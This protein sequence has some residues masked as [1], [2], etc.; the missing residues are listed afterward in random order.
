MAPL[1]RFRADDNHV[2]SDMAVEYYSQRASVPG[3]LII[4]E[5]TFLSPTAV[6]FLN[7]PMIHSQEQIAAWKRVIDAVHSKG[8]YIFCQLVASGREISPQVLEVT[9]QPLRGSSAIPMEPGAQVPYEMTENEVWGVVNDF[10]QAARNAIEAGF[11]GVEIHGANGYLTDQF[12]QD[13]ANQRTDQWGGSIENRSRFL[14]EISK[15]VVAAVGADRVGI[16]LSPFST[17]QGMGMADPFPQFSYLIRCLKDFKLAYLHMVE[18]RISGSADI[19]ATEKINFAVDIWGDTSPV[20]IAG[21]FTPD[22]AKRAV[23]DEYAGRDVGIVFGRY[24]ISNPDLPFRVREGIALNAYDRG[25]F[26]TPKS[27]QGYVDYPFSSEFEEEVARGR[28]Q[29]ASLQGTCDGC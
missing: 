6:G 18:S 1:T 16:R 4:T 28:L 14:L 20:L 26:Y 2:P 22:S 29:L 13:T 10:A 25:T 27:A 3:T 5:G 23:E 21:G 15:A 8:S 19:E 17:F 7:A 12:T 9:G 24:F 11:D